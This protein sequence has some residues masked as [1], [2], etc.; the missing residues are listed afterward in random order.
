M[1]ETPQ[2]FD[3]KE[4]DCDAKVVYERQTLIVYRG[5]G[6]SQ[7]AQP[8]APAGRV[9]RVYLRCARNHLHDY[10]VRA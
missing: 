6:E 8:A 7:N 4:A 2:V 3:C 9:I 5:P 1:A 10:A